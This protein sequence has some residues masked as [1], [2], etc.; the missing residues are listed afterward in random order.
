MRHF[1]TAVIFLAALAAPA[2]A[3]QQT[4][5]S[6]KWSGH[7]AAGRMIRVRNLNGP[8]T[9]TAGSGDRWRSPR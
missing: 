1:R 3:Q 9:V 6:F 8:I 5:N 7:I 2:L 4:D